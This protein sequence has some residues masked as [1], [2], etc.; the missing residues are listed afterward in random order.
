[1]KKTDIRET[2]N[3][4]YVPTQKLLSGLNVTTK[5]PISILKNIVYKKYTVVYGGKL[6]V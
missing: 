4:L 3:E 5:K 6:N 2:Q 1:M